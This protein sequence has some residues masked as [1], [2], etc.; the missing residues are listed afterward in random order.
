M[1]DA[2][3]HLDLQPNPRAVTAECERR[4]VHVLSVTTTPRAWQGTVALVRDPHIIRTALGI[5]PQ[6]A[7][8]AEQ[9]IALF[10]RLLP[11]TKFVGE[12]G[13]DCSNG[14]HTRLAEQIHIFGAV[15]SE[16]ENHGGRIL[17][18]HSRNATTQVLNQLESTIHRSIPILHW[19]SGTLAEL[20]RARQ[21]N[22]WFSVGPQMFYSAKGAKLIKAMPHERLLTES[23][24]PFAKILGKPVMPWDIAEHYPRLGLSLSLSVEET[25]EL[26]DSNFRRLLQ[27]LS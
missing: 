27:Q 24:S 10:M 15:L 3:C 23:D 22:C 25:S 17:S 13:I 20:E 5:H 18:I 19:F 26:V 16:C 7:V 1:V 14:H 21:L 8:N 12:I 4:G 2:H 11:E 6:L 9:E